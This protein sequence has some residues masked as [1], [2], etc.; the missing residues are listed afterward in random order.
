MNMPFDGLIPA[1]MTQ[2]IDAIAAAM[3]ITEDRAKKVTFSDP[4]DKSGLS[5][6]VRKD[7]QDKYKTADDS[8][9]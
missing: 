2:Q 9:D 8:K 1:L 3:S 7:S 4:H 6:I 5:I